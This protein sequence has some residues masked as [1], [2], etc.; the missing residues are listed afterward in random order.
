MLQQSDAVRAE[1][2]MHAA[3][4]DVQERWKRYQR[5]AAATTTDNG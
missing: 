2:L 5:L 3:Q 4:H 1:A